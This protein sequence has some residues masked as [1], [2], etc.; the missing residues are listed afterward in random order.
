MKRNQIKIGSVLSYVQMAL[1]I[2]IG[3]VYTPLMI[4]LLGQ[5]EYGLYNTVASTIS[6][7]SV[8]NLGFGSGYIRYYSKYKVNEDEASI[9]K[10]NGLFLIIFGII[11]CIAILCGAYLTTHLN[12]V[13]QNGLTTEEYSTAQILMWLLTFNLSISFPMSVFSN[14]I[15]AHERFVFLKIAGMGKNVLSPILTIPLLFLGYGSIGVVTVTVII[16]LIVDC[17]YVY[18]VFSRLRQRFVFHG[19]EKGIFRSLFA[20]TGFIA[21]NVIIDQIN[22][23]IDKVLLGRYMGTAVVAIYAVGATLQTYYNMFSTAVSS[24]FTPRIHSLANSQAAEIEINGKLTSL[25]MRVG[26]IQF[27]IL[28]LICSGFIFFGKPFIRFW[29]GE[30]YE[31]AYVVALLLI[32]PGTIPL[33]QNLGIEI[34]RAQNKHQFRGIAYALM[35][36]INL[37]MTIYLCQIYGAKGAAFGTSISLVIANGIVMNIYYY[38]RCGIDVIQ[39]WKS[40]GRLAI[41]ML[42]AFCVGVVMMKLI[43]INSWIVLIGCI[44]V[45]TLCY[46]TSVWCLSMNQEEKELIRNPLRR[47]VNRR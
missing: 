12:L 19:F 9:Q 20:Y 3:L 26:R 45:Y 37:I 17:I 42:P 11:A 16:S 36:V 15:S 22:W 39:F 8:L 18:Y 21:I 23:N 33:I 2:L 24:V 25:F 30:G 5:N 1:N 46:S 14:I 28:T 40:I 10:L 35:A 13:F 31:E 47:L 29:A 38:K 41:G 27:M 44:L 7:L 4:K 32:V 6:M 34:Q 43:T